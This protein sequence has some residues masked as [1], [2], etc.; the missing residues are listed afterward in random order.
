MLSTLRQLFESL[1][2]PDHQDALHRQHIAVVVL[3]LEVAK[4][5]HKLQQLEL[6]RLLLVIQERWCLSDDEAA[7]LLAAATREADQH[8]SL[9]EHLKLINARL[10]YSQRC[11]LV[12]G[13][14]EIAWA[15]DKIHH[16]EEH[17]IRRL[18]DL[19]YVSHADFIR[20]KHQAANKR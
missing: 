19:M 7:E 3:L 11:S 1:D 6:D 16:Y 2:E 5:D 4:S 15:D 13:L 8:T 14:W 9:H 17:L 12:G 10:D 18:A 20:T